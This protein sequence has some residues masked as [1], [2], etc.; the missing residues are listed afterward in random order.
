MIAYG[1]KK[2]LDTYGAT[3]KMRP[4]KSDTKH[5]VDH[6]NWIDDGRQDFICG[7]TL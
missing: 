3:L 6:R 5:D 4:S 1:C 7:A 2:V